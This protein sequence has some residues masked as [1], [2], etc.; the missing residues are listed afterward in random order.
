M[1]RVHSPRLVKFHGK[2][3]TSKPEEIPVKTLDFDREPHRVP[4]RWRTL[5]ALTAASPSE[6]MHAA[7]DKIRAT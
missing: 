4:A 3:A 7:L 6:S 5:A 1:F 2:F